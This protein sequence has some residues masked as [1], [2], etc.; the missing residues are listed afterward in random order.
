M[1]SFDWPNVMGFRRCRKGHREKTTISREAE[2]RKE[3]TRKCVRWKRDKANREKEKER[4]VIYRLLRGCVGFLAK[5]AWRSEREAHVG[6]K[7]ETYEG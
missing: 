7:R 2:G 6:D 3:A 4:D 1:R 5:G